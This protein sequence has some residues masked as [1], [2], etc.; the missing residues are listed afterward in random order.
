MKTSECR[1][2]SIEPGFGEDAIGRSREAA[3]SRGLFDS[4]VARGKDGD[5]DFA[6]GGRCI[7]E[8]DA[9]V[10]S[11][12][13]L[14]GV[15]NDRSRSSTGNSR[16]LGTE[17]RL[18]IRPGLTHCI[19]LGPP[20]IGALGAEKPSRSGGG[21]IGGGRGAI[22]VR[23]AFGPVGIF[24]GKLFGEVLAGAAPP[25]RG[26]RAEAFALGD[27]SR[28]AYGGKG[29]LENCGDAFVRKAAWGAMGGGRGLGAGP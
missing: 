15:P 8:L 17:G 26:P 20:L 7:W 27:A 3:R 29:A 13:A 23:S 28:G 4:A 14:G 21:Y 2:T 1:L 16:L 25:L 19:L 5:S 24:A 11:L 6:I 18:G 9:L 10:S 22:G 12:G